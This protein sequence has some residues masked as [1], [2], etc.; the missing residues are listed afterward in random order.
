[1]DSLH[2]HDH[3][4][5]TGRG[6]GSSICGLLLRLYKV[7]SRGEHSDSRV[8]DAKSACLLAGLRHD[9]LDESESHTLT[10]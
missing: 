9:T 1:M 8:I 10:K 3:V 7:Y 6:K 5:I 2:C 4:T